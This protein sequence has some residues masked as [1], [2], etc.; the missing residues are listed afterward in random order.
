MTWITVDFGKDYTGLST[1]GVVQLQADGSVIVPRTS[2]GLIAFGNGFYGMNV[3]FDPLAIAVQWDTG[4]DVPLYASEN[5]G[6]IPVTPADNAAA[7]WNFL[8]E[9]G[10]TAEQILSFVSSILAGKVSGAGSG[11]EVFRDL[12]DTMD[13]VIVTTDQSGNRLDVVRNGT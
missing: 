13:R 9:A 11:T 2:N 10:Y 8:I 6:D 5:I 3:T 1:V 4:T 7:T 12:G